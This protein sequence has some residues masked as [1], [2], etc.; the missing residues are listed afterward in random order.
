[1]IR[2]YREVIREASEELLLSNGPLTA[3]EIRDIGAEEY[4]LSV[5]GH[6]GSYSKVPDVEIKKVLRESDRFRED[7]TGR[8]HLAVQSSYE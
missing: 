7:D 3:N 1:M 8:F 5:S 2:G 6:R 4:T